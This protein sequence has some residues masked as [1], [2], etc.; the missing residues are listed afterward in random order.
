[1][2]GTSGRDNTIIRNPLERVGFSPGLG[3]NPAGDR[4]VYAI[5]EGQF[6]GDR[7]FS[8]KFYLN[9]SS[10]LVSLDLIVRE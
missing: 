10:E 5:L 3:I 1:M 4:Q 2:E 6:S 9:W 8:T 7:K